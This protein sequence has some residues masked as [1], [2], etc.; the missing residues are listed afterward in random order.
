MFIGEYS[1]TLDKKNRL[2][3]PVKFRKDLGDNAVITR[4]LDNS[5]Q[6]YPMAAWKEIAVKLGEMPIGESQTRSFVRLML[7]GAAEVSL[8]KLGRILIPEYL[9][10][11]AG[12]KKDTKI[13]GLFNR[14]E[15][16]DTASWDSYKNRA[17][18]DSNKAAEKLG[19]LGVF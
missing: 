19:E 5:L 16:W 9:K 13:N 3:V 4:G 12:L 2:A 6:L 14:V 17:E 8:D 1:H 7:A 18:K 10:K 15:I 11:F